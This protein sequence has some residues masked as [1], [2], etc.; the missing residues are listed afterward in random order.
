MATIMQYVCEQCGARHAPGNM[1]T[2][3]SEAV[4]NTIASCATCQGRRALELA[5]PFA[6]GACGGQVVVVAAFVPRAAVS[7]CRFWEHD[8]HTIEYLPFLVVL[9]DKHEHKMRNIW[10]PYW[11]LDTHQSSGKTTMKYGQWAPLMDH[12][13]FMD[14]I[15]QATA[16]GYLPTLHSR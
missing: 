12:T 14:L 3:L 11:H 7:S 6:F 5:F 1:L 8:G 13:L 10:L 15:E 2:A 16:A 4:K 9:E